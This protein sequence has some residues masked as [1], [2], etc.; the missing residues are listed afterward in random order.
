MYK[1]SSCSNKIVLQHCQTCKLLLVLIEDIC[2]NMKVAEFLEKIAFKESVSKI[3]CTRVIV[4]F[5]EQAHE[6]KSRS[7]IY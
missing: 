5:M 3:L 7:W 2:D 4:L 6:S 1:T